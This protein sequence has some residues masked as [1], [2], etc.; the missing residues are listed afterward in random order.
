MALV[1]FNI[2]I[3]YSSVVFNNI[4]FNPTFTPF[5]Y[6]NITSVIYINIT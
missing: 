3:S 6:T 1:R 4:V 2:I 5:I